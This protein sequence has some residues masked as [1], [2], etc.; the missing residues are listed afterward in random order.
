MVSRYRTR[1]HLI[2]EGGFVKNRYGTIVSDPMYGSSSCADYVPGPGNLAI[3]HNT[4]GYVAT[5]GST[6]TTIG[7]G[8]YAWHYENFR[9]TSFQAPD[10][11]WVPDINMSVAKLRARTNPSKPDID[12][13][14]FILE[15]RDVPH[16]LKFL[17][18]K[19]ASFARKAANGNLAYQFGVKPL[20]S[21]LLTLFD[22][23][24]RIEARK[25]SLVK[26]AGFEGMRRRIHLDNRSFSYD[27]Y[28]IGSFSGGY[29]G[30]I[31][32]EADSRVWGVQRYYATP[33]TLSMLSYENIDTTALRLTLGLNPSLSQV[34]ELL[35]WSW[36]I[37][38]FSN[39]GDLVAAQRNYL[40]MVPGTSWIMWETTSRAKM[41]L[42]KPDRN[43]PDDMRYP[44][45]SNASL[46]RRE[47]YGSEGALLS[48]EL[49]ILTEVQSSILLSLSIVKHKKLLQRI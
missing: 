11:Q 7:D 26:M 27:P 31:Q 30:R 37:D 14:V 33:S 49:P 1:K 39:I 40:D 36:L 5:S 10:P 19:G 22:L 25:K 8:S 42:I 32:A 16:T 34:W 48:V 38:Y 17:Y 18:E 12:L 15:L 28:I 44:V 23:S 20:V 45:F 35:P 9:E 46:I 43:D 2:H 13:P 24:A 4:P 3:V 41:S 21:D 29:Y 6:G 47:R